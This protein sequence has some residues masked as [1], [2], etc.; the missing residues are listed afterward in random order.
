MTANSPKKITSASLFQRVVALI[1]DLFIVIVLGSTVSLGVTEISKRI[2]SNINELQLY[3]DEVDNSQIFSEERSED[4][5]EL[6]YSDNYLNYINRLSHFYTVYL[7]SKKYYEKTHDTYWFNVHVLGLDDVKGIYNENDLNSIP[8]VIAN[9][10]KTLFEYYGTDYDSLGIA[11]DLNQN[12][13]ATLNNDSLLKLRKYFLLNKNDNEEDK[14][15]CVLYYALQDFITIDDVV[16]HYNQYRLFTYILPIY[17]S[18]TISMIVFMVVIPACLKRGKTLGKLAFGL[19]VISE[20]G[21]EAKRSQVALRNLPLILFTLINLLMFG[22]N[23]ITVGVITILVMVSFI[24]M[25]VSKDHK[26]LHDKFFYTIVIKDKQSVWFKNS[27]EEE[28]FTEKLDK[29]LD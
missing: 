7:P 4:S 6:Y 2:P 9:N 13:L 26:A 1:M 21:Y 23:V 29:K 24:M 17:C 5:L 20:N 16:N 25:I 10:G 15:N 12:T 22:L 27:L 3:Y 8:D 11:K 28:K 14:S 19:S 18:I